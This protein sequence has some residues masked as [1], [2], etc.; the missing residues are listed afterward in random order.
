M[1]TIST[2]SEIEK[3]PTGAARCRRCNKNIGK[4]TPRARFPL[5]NEH[6]SDGFYCYKCS[7]T[8]IDDSIKDLGEEIKILKTLKINLSKL[9]EECSKEIIAA[10][11]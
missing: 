9:M 10:N 5:N 1:G 4:G 3:S 6:N 2:I 8:A 11:L 7:P